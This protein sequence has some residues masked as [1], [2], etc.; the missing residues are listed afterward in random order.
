ML[1]LVDMHEVGDGEVVEGILLA[2]G[3]EGVFKRKR[4]FQAG[5]QSKTLVDSSE[6][7]LDAE[8][9][10]T[11]LAKLVKKNDSAF[12]SKKQLTPIQ[13]ADFVTQAR[14][15]AGD[16]APEAG[17]PP[18]ASG[19]NAAADEDDLDEEDE[20]LAEQRADAALAMLSPAARKAQASAAKALSKKRAASAGVES[21]QPKKKRSTASLQSTLE[22]AQKEVAELQQK[23]K[24]MRLKAGPLSNAR[25]SWELILQKLVQDVGEKADDLSQEAITAQSDLCAAAEG[26]ANLNNAYQAFNKVSANSQKLRGL[27]D[28][29]EAH[30]YINEM[31]R[32]RSADEIRNFIP[33]EWHELAMKL[34]ITRALEEKSS[35]DIIKSVDLGHII[36]SLSCTK[37]AASALQKSALSKLVSE[38]MQTKASFEEQI[39]EIL[40]WLRPLMSEQQILG[41]G[42]AS[43]C[44]CM[45]R[46]TDSEAEAETA[47]GVK[48]ETE[49]LI[50]D[51]KACQQG[52]YSDHDS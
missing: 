45:L 37:E 30:E 25:K 41:P 4:K 17:E 8:Q 31:G 36:G 11:N 39:K 6:N 40:M 29:R 18:G 23:F 19:A 44:L 2:V 3:E 46:L 48:M 5:V 47:D 1:H 42:L 27:A 28:R 52:P 24:T 13:L 15:K 14:A 34:E 43:D 26:I 35:D 16:E 7:A 49:T 50:S 32:A 21:A 38:I 12:N 9:L 51:A 22:K 10:D 33:M 20:Y